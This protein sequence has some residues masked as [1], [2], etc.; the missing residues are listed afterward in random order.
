M[1]IRL[2]VIMDPIHKINYKKDSTL[3]MLFEA[4]ARGYELLYFEQE[5]IY[6][7]DGKV[8]GKGRQLD[9]FRDE[10][11]WF[12]LGDFQE[13]DLASLNILLMRKDPPFNQEYIYT[14]YLLE[15]VERQKV[16]VVNKPQGLRDA[17]EKLFIANFPD[18]APPT[19]VTQ[20]RDVLYAFL[21]QHHDIVCKPLHTMGGQ[22]IFRITQDDV[23]TNVIFDTLT[24]NQTAFV[25]VQRFIPAIVEG[26]KRIILIDGE[27]VMHALV[28]V[29]QAGDWRGNLAVGAK[30]IIAPLSKRDQFICSKLGPSLREH[31]LYFVGIDVIGDY[32]TEVNVTSPTG[33]REIDAGLNIN[34]SSTLYDHLEKHL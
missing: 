29:P 11:K 4:E 26:D 10:K 9:V 13:I 2:G 22:S 15:L 30:G 7:Q 1:T 24:H 33:I 32:L 6:L 12:E 14:T 27:P 5:Y 17:N 8:F 19:A 20:S 16:L 28:R 18:L 31:G 21:Q 3:A 25:M 34:I 23:N